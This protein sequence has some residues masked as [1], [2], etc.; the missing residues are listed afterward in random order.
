M[1][2]TLTNRGYSYVKS[3]RRVKSVWIA[4]TEQYTRKPSVG[5]GDGHEINN[6]YLLRELGGT[7]RMV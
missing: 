5:P 4:Y 2:M 7:L 3:G 1:R 6:L